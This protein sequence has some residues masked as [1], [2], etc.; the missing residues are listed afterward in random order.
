MHELLTQPA[1]TTIHETHPFDYF[2]VYGPADAK[3]PENEIKLK[4]KIKQ[5]FIYSDSDSSK[6]Q[7]Q[8][9]KIFTKYKPKYSEYKDIKILQI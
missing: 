4:F 6:D 5:F 3:I 2:E 8:R 7:F 9:C 1:I